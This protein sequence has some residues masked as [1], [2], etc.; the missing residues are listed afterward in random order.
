MPT[1]VDLGTLAL[2]AGQTDV[3]LPSSN[4]QNV[5]PGLNFTNI[6]VHISLTQIPDGTTFAWDCDWSLTPNGSVWDHQGG[7]SL[8]LPAHNKDGSLATEMIQLQGIPTGARRGRL[9][10]KQVSQNSTITASVIAFP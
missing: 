10:I 3:F 5:P 4:G 2:T 1:T 6:E 8:S 9:H 7:A